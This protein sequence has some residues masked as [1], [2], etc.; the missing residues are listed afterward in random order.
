MIA[1]SRFTVAAHMLTLLAQNPDEPV[2]SEHI[3]ASVNT[4]PV[5]IRRILGTLRS[6]RL[7][8]SQGGNG[9]GW[10]LVSAPAAITL[11]DVYQAVE[12]KP[13]FPPHHQSPNQDCPVGRHIQQALKGAFAS[14]TQ[15]L[16]NELA[17]TSVAD[18]LR[19]VQALAR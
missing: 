15:A 7:V 18:L 10:R 6:A 13:L 5:V 4:N 14:A 9:G 12:D 2:T 16:E 17:R 8:M 3:A 1:N 19:E 11:R